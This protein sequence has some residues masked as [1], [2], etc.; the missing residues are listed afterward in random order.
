MKR[1]TIH[2]CRLIMLTAMLIGLLW[3]CCAHAYDGNIART[4]LDQF[5]LAIE[6]IQPIGDPA[7]TV[8]PARPGEYLHEYDFGTV[9]ASSAGRISGESI[10]SV[11]VRTAQVTDCQGLRVGM[12]VAD[13]LQG[14]QVGAGSTPLYVLDVD[15][16]KR[17]WRWAYVSDGR[18]YGVELIAYAGQGAHMTEYTL[19]YVIDEGK[20]SAIRMKT[21]PATQ[22]QANDALDMAQEIAAR[23][24]GELMAVANNAAMFA[25]DDNR[26]AEVEA[27]GAEVASV[28][29]RLGEPLQIQ[30]LPDGA[31][32]I[33]LYEDAVITLALDEYTGV[34]V[35]RSV[36]VGGE[37]IKGP[38]RLSVGMTVQEA[39][40]L[41][42]CDQDVSSLGGA[43]YLEG[44]A[45]GEA[46]CGML[47]RNDAGELVLSYACMTRSGTVMMLQAGIRE[48]E[49]VYWRL[50]D[51]RDAEEGI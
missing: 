17:C 48:G 36:S 20:I 34:E 26:I 33:L 4:W 39:A 29:A 47:V 42:R 22:A 30:T 27:L 37:S 2:F 50:F 46:P 51:S 32:R 11:D 31:G 12:S 3:P 35:V 23:Q 15:A 14:A 6:H 44:E 19:T 21:A 25:E 7:M 16:E 10:L 9:A 49:I 5:A 13:A 45:L 8:D 1:E 18:I 40:S 28:V 38:R 41:F 24:H 43:L